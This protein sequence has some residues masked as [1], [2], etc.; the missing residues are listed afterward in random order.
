MFK[1]W[2]LLLSRESWSKSCERRS[3]GLIA[4]ITTLIG[5]RETIFVDESTINFP[6]FNTKFP[7]FPNFWIL[8]FLFSYFFEHSWHWTPWLPVKWMTHKTWKMLEEQ[9][10]AVFIAVISFRVGKNEFSYIAVNISATGS[11]IVNTQLYI[12]KTVHYL[13]DFKMLLS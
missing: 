8:S 9:L 11:N 2:S 4:F 7:I 10:E 5:C 6:I 13:S 3:S 12:F 1:Y